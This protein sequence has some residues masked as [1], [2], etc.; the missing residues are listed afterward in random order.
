[1]SK[2][3]GELKKKWMNDILPYWIE[4]RTTYEV[5]KLAGKGIPTALREQIWMLATDNRLC[6]TK[7]IFEMLRT[8][9]REYLADLGRSTLREHS[10][11]PLRAS[12]GSPLKQPVDKLGSIKMID[13][14]LPR[15]FS[16]HAIF[17]QNSPLYSSLREV[18]ATFAHYRP[19]IGYV[20]GMSYI[21]ALLL[22]HMDEFKAF[23]VFANLI[24][25]PSLLP[26]YLL[27]DIQVNGRMS[28]F[29]TMFKE[30]LPKLHKH[31]EGEGV[32]PKMFFFE[33]LLTLYTKALDFDLVSRIWDLFFFEGPF[34]I[35][36]TAIG[37]Y[38]RS[39]A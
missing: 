34:V 37:T 26:I 16:N 24:C 4:K 38:T 14:D 15:T 21:C 20:Q 17:R 36:R 33:W 7:A 19:D 11:T 23:V 27:D 29:S 1:M 31:F 39:S 18:L 9:G 12:S 32:H 28:V 22:L 35:Y 10:D 8:K 3:K 2:K 5:R 6:L 25:Q 13:L 30:T